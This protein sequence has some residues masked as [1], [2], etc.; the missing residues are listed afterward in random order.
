MSL[1]N[2]VY[3]VIV[4]ILFTDIPFYQLLGWDT[5]ST[6]VNYIYR[7]SP[8]FYVSLFTSF[9]ILLKARKGYKIELKCMYI[10]VCVVLLMLYIGK[11]SVV[12]N[13]CTC[14]VW[15]IAVSVC[16]KYLRERSDGKYLHII[17]ILFLIVE[18]GIAIVERLFH[19]NFLPIIYDNSSN[20]TEYIKN[21]KEE[22]L[23]FRSTSLHG[24][25]LT[26]A[27]FVDTIISFILICKNF[28]TKN[29]IQLYVI[30]YIA[31]LCFN[32]RSSI[33]IMPLV[34][35]IYL[36]NQLLSKNISGSSKLI[37]LLYSFLGIII[38][39]Y[40][41]FELGFGGRMLT[42]DIMDD[43]AEARLQ[44]W[45]LFQFIST[46][47]LI[48]GA[49][50]HRI[51]KMSIMYSQGHIEN[52]LIIFIFNYGLIILSVLLVGMAAIFKTYLR[53]LEK[54]SALFVLFVFFIIA[55]TNN[56]LAVGTLAVQFFFISAWS[57][58]SPLRNFN[59]AINP[60]RKHFNDT[61]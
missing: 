21:S 9:L 49:D 44:A 57:F 20:L 34:L 58:T 31:I 60:K 52:W 12:I 45:D 7:L 54:F 48:W 23:G 24:H 15:P 56:S 29:K 10:C 4:L 51:N 43:S 26:N 17:L 53:H 33:I 35:G 18:C 36:L 50:M 40:L 47:D 11:M 2:L 25:P 37:Y 14:F 41:M 46:E 38:A 32:A 39:Y 28:S 59:V 27:L 6:S 22:L 55:S 16:I 5:L 13:L 30:G 3:I 8:V 19:Y 42:D 61:R 1:R